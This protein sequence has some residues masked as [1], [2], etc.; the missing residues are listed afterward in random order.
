VREGRLASFFGRVNYTLRDRWIFMAS[1]RRDGSSRFGPGNQWGTFPAAAVAWRIGDEAFMQD[2]GA[3]SD[4]KLRASWGING[5]QTVADYLWIANYAFGDAFARVQ[6]GDEFLTTIRPTAVDPNIKW[7]ETT[8]WNVGL[9]YGFM[10]DRVTGTL[11]YYVKDTDDLLFRVPVAAGTAVSNSI[12]TNVG[13]I[14]NQ[15]IEFGIDAEVLPADRPGL[16]WSVNFNAARNSNEITR[17]NPFGGGGERILVG[18]IAGGVGSTIQVLQPGIAVNS[19]FVYEHRRDANGNPV[20]SGDDLEMYVDQ[21]D[22][23]VINQNDRV[24]HESPAPDWILG[25][26][27][28][29]GYGDFDLSFTL[30]AQL[31]NHVYNNLASSQGYYGRLNEAAGPVNLHASVLETGFERPQFFSDVYVEDASFLR[32]DNVTL[33]WNV[34]RSARLQQM[35][36]FATIQN[37]F[38]VTGYSGVDPLVGLNGIDNSVYPRSRTYTA[39]I[40]VGF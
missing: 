33:G 39:G 38:T 36:V 28:S 18:G 12:T 3:L 15:G 16:R 32:M 40:T 11:D 35:R 21:N 7:E 34:P 1:V 22:D 8:S 10:D 2:V 19:F 20:N 26:T 37:A 30:S 6:F 9:D 24:A 17:I 29:F 23:G 14:R 27:S 13:S 31:G 25:H 4:L 5:N